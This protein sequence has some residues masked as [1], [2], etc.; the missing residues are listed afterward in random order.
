MPDPMGNPTRAARAA[1]R[2]AVLLAA[3][4]CATAASAADEPYAL[5]LTPAGDAAARSAI[6]KQADF[7]TADGWKGGP[8][9][10]PPASKE[11]GCD[12][13]RPKRSDLVLQGSRAVAFMASALRFDSRADV[14]KT[15]A[16]ARL[17]WQ[18]TMRAP[19]FVK[20]MRKGMETGAHIVSL[21]PLKLPKI[22][23]RTVG[24]RALA[25]TRNTSTKGYFLFDVIFVSQ[26]RTE[27]TLF[28]TSPPAAAASIK[29]AE[30]RI[31][32]TLIGR[33]RA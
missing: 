32:R 12:S 16:M 17:D 13:F 8:V 28:T 10:Q 26:G 15:P 19:G 18:R 9:D 25:E 23:T 11:Q 20:C 5:D 29:Q 22:A 21:R 6:L 3:L 2:A 24:Y 14:F 31:L 30:I 27:I 4:V 7:G 33:A 1:T